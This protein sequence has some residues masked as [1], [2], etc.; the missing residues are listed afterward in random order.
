VNAP[1]DGWIENLIAEWDRAVLLR[2]GEK[3]EAVLA[4]VGNGLRNALRR[5]VKP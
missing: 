2:S 1:D 4:E 5:V 3:R